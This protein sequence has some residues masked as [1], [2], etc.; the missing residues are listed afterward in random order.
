MAGVMAT[1]R[2][3]RSGHV[4]RNADVP[5]PGTRVRGMEG[6]RDFDQSKGICLA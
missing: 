3:P 6:L 5:A 2:L 1:I 4:A